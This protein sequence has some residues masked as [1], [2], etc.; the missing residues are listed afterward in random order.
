MR[1]VFA[2]LVVVGIL[3]LRAYLHY[4]RISKGHELNKPTNALFGGDYGE[5]AKKRK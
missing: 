1:S 5:A 4:R 3:G 2:G